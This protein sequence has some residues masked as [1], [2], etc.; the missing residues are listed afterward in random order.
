M[1]H[2]IDDL[3]AISKIKN[4]VICKTDKRR[5]VE[6]LN[7]DIYINKMTEQDTA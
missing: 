5:D 7:N 4:E 6:I 1:S 2:Y 3:V